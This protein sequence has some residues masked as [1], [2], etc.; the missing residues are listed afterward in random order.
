MKEIALMHFRKDRYGFAWDLLQI[1]NRS[2]LGLGF[3]N[4]ALDG[5][6]NYQVQFDFLFLQMTF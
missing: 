4:M 1:N 2:L 5:K 3:V 6:R